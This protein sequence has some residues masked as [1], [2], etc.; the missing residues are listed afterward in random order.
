MEK[1]VSIISPQAPADY[2]EVM[3]KKGSLRQDEN[4][5]HIFIN[6]FVPPTEKRI[7]FGL[8]SDIRELIANAIDGKATFRNKEYDLTQGRFRFENLNIVFRPNRM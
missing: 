6:K 2:K 7:E 4:F 1:V 3:D 8:R 5:S